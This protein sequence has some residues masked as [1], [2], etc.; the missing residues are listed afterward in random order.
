MKY[1]LY[2]LEWIS[3]WVTY[4]WTLID[5]YPRSNTIDSGHIISIFLIFIHMI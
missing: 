3:F 1:R 5:T 2:L 4:S